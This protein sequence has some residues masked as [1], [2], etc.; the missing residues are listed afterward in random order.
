VAAAGCA[1]G[2][3]G[4]G[5]TAAFAIGVASLGDA[6]WTSAFFAGFFLAAGVFLG[7]VALVTEIFLRFALALPLAFFL[8]AIYG[9]P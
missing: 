3:A 2:L 7:V 8:V 1:G 6:R 4:L 9:L 5:F